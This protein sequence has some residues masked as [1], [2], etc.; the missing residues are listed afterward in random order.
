[1]LL[2]YKNFKSNFPKKKNLKKFKIQ[3]VKNNRYN[4]TI[5]NFLTKSKKKCI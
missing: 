4:K 1:M 2:S 3:S 5:H